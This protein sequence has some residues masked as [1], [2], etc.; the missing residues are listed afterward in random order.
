MRTTDHS[1]LS[2][3]TVIRARQESLV[4][5]FSQ[6][7]QKQSPFSKRHRSVASPSE[8]VHCVPTIEDPYCKTQAFWHKQAITEIL[9]R[10]K[11]PPPSRTLPDHYDMPEYNNDGRVPGAMFLNSKF[12][13]NS[14]EQVRRRLR[15]NEINHLG[16]EP[17]LEGKQGSKYFKGVYEKNNKMHVLE[18]WE[19][20]D[21]PRGFYA[22]TSRLHE[23]P[24][25]S[26]KVHPTPEKQK[27][28][29]DELAFVR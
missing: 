5:A 25:F 6:T 13:H 7:Y 2:D 29:E 18:N 10:T 23:D 19:A 1:V 26:V 11:S 3:R 17:Q 16:Y 24:T 22:Y 9:G 28:T 15:L 8:I 21:E 20:R 4:Q 27:L 14:M 12:E